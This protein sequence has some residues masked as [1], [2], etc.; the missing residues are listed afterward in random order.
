VSS[1]S[2]HSTSAAAEAHPGGST[3]QA[4]QGPARHAPAKPGGAAGPPLPS[5]ERSTTAQPTG[6]RGLHAAMGVVASQVG[7]RTSG[8]GLLGDGVLPEG[9]PP[10]RHAR[11]LP[12]LSVVVGIN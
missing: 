8:G 3:A 1:A 6:V 7:G 5:S 11:V 9:V 12:G 4:Q 10:R 2:A